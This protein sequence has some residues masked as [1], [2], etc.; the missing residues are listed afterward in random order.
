MEDDAAGLV[1]RLA[2]KT[3]FSE[4]GWG[5]TPPS[6]AK[7]RRLPERLREQFAKLSLRKR[8]IGSNPIPSASKCQRDWVVR[9]VL[10]TKKH[11]G[12]TRKARE[13]IANLFYAG[14]IPVTYSKN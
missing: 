4:M 14:S 1:L 5:S 13:Q 2:L 11:V 6:S 8:R 3:R 9:E 7:H 10:K 12:V